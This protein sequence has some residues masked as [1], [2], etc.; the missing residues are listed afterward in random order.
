VIADTLW[1]PKLGVDDAHTDDA[2]A[3]SDTTF[4][5]ADGATQS[6]LSGRWARCLVDRAVCATDVWDRVPLLVQKACAE[7]ASVLDAYK[8][9]RDDAGRP[10]MYYEDPKLERGSHTTLL[11]VQAVLLQSTR[12]S[13]YRVI[14]VGDSCIFHISQDQF[15]G[16]FP[17]IYSSAFD[18]S[19]ELISSAQHA[20]EPP[21]YQK[22]YGAWDV[23]DRLFLLTDALAHWFLRE[24]ERG[25]RPWVTLERLNETTF[26][27]WVDDE[28]H[29]G[30]IRDDDVTMTRIVLTAADQTLDV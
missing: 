15:A 14:G 11:V 19:P 21:R 13:I 6:Y 4:A 3:S 18:T 12:S 8:V 29:A 1:A 23:G 2:F 22:V 9:E 25:G 17:F 30:H 24:Y 10:I 27:D 26:R 28:R 20:A 5:I 7:W 16:A